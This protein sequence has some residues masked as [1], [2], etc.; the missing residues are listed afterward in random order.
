[1]ENIENK[2]SETPK[3]VNLCEDMSSHTHDEKDYKIA[4][5]H[6]EKTKEKFQEK[7]SE[8]N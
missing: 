6:Q 1:M 7:S 3:V 5:E 4:M 2:Q 8:A